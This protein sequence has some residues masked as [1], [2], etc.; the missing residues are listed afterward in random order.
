MIVAK[1][2][3]IGNW[4]LFP[5]KDIRKVEGWMFIQECKN[6]QPI[7][8]TE[9]ILLKCGFSRV[10]GIHKRYIKEYGAFWFEILEQAKE[11]VWH[12][13]L[14]TNDG[15]TLTGLGIY[16]FIHQLQNLYFALTGEELNYNP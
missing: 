7:P 5:P 10:T 15:M 11:N 8:L 3:R 13:M 4:V 14:S 6:M 16:Y 12:L 1:D 2:L 9:E